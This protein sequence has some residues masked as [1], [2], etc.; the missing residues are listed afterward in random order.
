MPSATNR[1]DLL[2]ILAADC[3][4]PDAEVGCDC[5][6]QCCDDDDG[7]TIEYDSVCER[8]ASRF[9]SP[10]GSF[11]HDEAGANCGCSGSGVNTTMTCLDERC[12]NTCNQDDTVCVS[13]E[14]YSS[15][16]MEN[17]AFWEYFRSTYR[18][19]KGRNDTV[20]FES[21]LQLNWR[22]RYTVTINGEE[23]NSAS[24][25]TC[26]YGDR[27]YSVH[28]D[29]IPGAGSVRICKDEV[30]DDQGPLAVFAFQ[31]PTYRKSGG[32]PP[33]FYPLA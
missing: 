31:D 33:R 27:A 19:T 23:C 28:C 3:A 7:C 32:C 20:V 12:T 11:Y 5:C 29:N 8:F 9:D 25:T 2:T 10:S 4:G 30:Y 14:E 6:A 24:L 16:F 13:H 15:G 18:Y 1:D 22:W 26:P 17:Y 21:V